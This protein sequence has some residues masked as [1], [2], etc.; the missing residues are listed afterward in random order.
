MTL[1]ATDTLTQ[2]VGTLILTGLRPKGDR[3]RLER[4]KTYSRRHVVKQLG[5]D[6]SLHTVRHGVGI[7]YFLTISAEDGY[8]YR[9]SLTDYE[10]GKVAAT[11][12]KHTLGEPEAPAAGK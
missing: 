11:Y 2:S 12:Q 6:N 4:Y 1:G 10:A 8:T 5:D 7:A 3:M 9:L